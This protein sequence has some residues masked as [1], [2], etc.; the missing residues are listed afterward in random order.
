MRIKDSLSSPGFSIEWIIIAIIMWLNPLV[1]KLAAV[2]LTPNEQFIYE[3]THYYDLFSRF[4][5][6]AL[7]VATGI[8]LLFFIIGQLTGGKKPRNM[9][10]VLPVAIYA[11]ITVISAI[12]GL[13]KTVAFRGLIDRYE[14]LWIL[15][16]YCTLFIVCTQQQIENSFHKRLLLPLIA[17]FSI[18]LFIGLPQP[19]GL[20]ILNSDFYK[21]IAIGYEHLDKVSSLFATTLTAYSTLGNP[22]FLGSYMALILPL[23]FFV[24][25]SSEKKWKYVS[26]FFWVLG[27]CLMI[28]SRSLAGLAGFI[29][30]HAVLIQFLDT[31]RAI[32]AGVLYT[33]TMIAAIIYDSLSPNVM[34]DLEYAGVLLSGVFL[35]IILFGLSKYRFR[36]TQ[37]LISLILLFAIPSAIFYFNY[38]KTVNTNSA[39]Y[40]NTISTEGNVLTID[41]NKNS[42]RTLLQI[43]SNDRHLNFYDS[44][45]LLEVLKKAEVNTLVG[46]QY[47]DFDYGLLLKKEYDFLMFSKLQCGFF[48]KN[49]KFYMMNSGKNSVSIQHPSKLPF[50]HYERLGSGRA[51][52]W[53][54][55]IPLLKDTAIFGVGPDNFVFKFPQNDLAGKLNLGNA[56]LIV[57]KPHNWYL[58]MAINS[59]LG[60]M[61]CILYLYYKTIR[62]YLIKVKNIINVQLDQHLFIGLFSSITGYHVAA[63]FNDSVIAVAPV[64]WILYGLLIASLNNTTT[65]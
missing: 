33:V 11:I 52:I 4:R 36:Y 16:S 23:F 65:E 17:S 44:G 1:V 29:I 12:N 42:Q 38:T 57:D 6:T 31:K 18:V 19:L 28:G 61:F 59:G 3:R 54:R 37:L 41:Y 22:N 64:F 26:A 51:Y 20:N 53:S 34:L 5:G 62:L 50:D 47:S 32:Q 30:G 63:L 25:I 13:D 45:K 8:L 21:A 2:P 9:G 40:I 58:Q 15:L 24:F 56:L 49:N 10:F 55:S 60:A 14:G 48:I 35:W 7:L 43:K 27:V 46:N 39:L